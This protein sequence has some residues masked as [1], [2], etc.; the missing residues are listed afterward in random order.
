MLG[1]SVSPL[2]I[3]SPRNNRYGIYGLV[4]NVLQVNTGTST[5]DSW[6]LSPSMRCRIPALLGP[7]PWLQHELPGPG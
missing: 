6:Y 3:R 4:M 1:A 2:S 7:E 5:C